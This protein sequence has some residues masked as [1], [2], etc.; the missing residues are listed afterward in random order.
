M[1]IVIII[2]AVVFVVVWL[3]PGLGVIHS[4]NGLTRC[5]RF[6]MVR[7]SGVVPTGKKAYLNGK[8]FPGEK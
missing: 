6:S 5:G 4:N 8:N 2:M 3:Y 7:I 1:I